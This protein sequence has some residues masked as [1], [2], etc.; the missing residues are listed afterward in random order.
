MTGASNDSLSD[1]L[2]NEDIVGFYPREFYPFD[3]FAAFQVIWK[4]VLW[5]TAEHTCQAAH[6]FDTDPGPVEQIWNA[7]SPAE[8]FRI[9]NANA[10]R[11]AKDWA[12]KKLDVMYEICRAKLEQHPLVQ[13][14]LLET[15]DRL[16]V[17]DS[18]VDSFWGWGPDRDGRNELGKIW[19]RLRDELRAG[20]IFGSR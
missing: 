5:P 1:N 18:P 17:E 2:T 4:D 13:Q 15:G 6:F 7:T 8:A 10:D 11:E 14:R 12:N 16:I 19:M 20:A 3:N 9:A